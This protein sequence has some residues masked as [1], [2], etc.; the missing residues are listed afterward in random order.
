[1]LKNSTQSTMC[2]P[3]HWLQLGC[4]P[5]LW[6]ALLDWWYRIKSPTVLFGPLL[7][8]MWLLVTKNVDCVLY[9]HHFM[10]KLHSQYMVPYNI[11]LP[12]SLHKTLERHTSICIE[13]VSFLNYMLPCTHPVLT[14]VFVTG[15][16][17]SAATAELSL[18]LCVWWWCTRGNY[19]RTQWPL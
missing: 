10:C 15:F 8:V 4:K 17:S 19:K 13:D 14:S 9:W 18:S 5:I 7:F 11:L 16:V 2:K 3:S 12:H 6:G 1:M